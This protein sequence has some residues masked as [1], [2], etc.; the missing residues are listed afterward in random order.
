M[1]QQPLQYLFHPSALGQLTLVSSPH[2]ICGIYFHDQRSYT[3]TAGWHAARRHALLEQAGAELD[4]YF[5]GQ[6]KTFTVP[7]DLA[8]RG[9]AFQ[10]DVWMELLNI[11]YGSTSTY[12]RHAELLARPR[13]MR[14]VGAAIGR[15]PISIMV[16]CHRVIGR[17]GSLT[18]YDG[19]LERKHYLLQL[20]GAL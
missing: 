16:P 17:D 7:L 9:T 15:N 12:G 20:E 10:H 19:G 6:R 4:E 18:G 14:A 11:D 8:L 5:A 2:G 3:G 13:A 1:D